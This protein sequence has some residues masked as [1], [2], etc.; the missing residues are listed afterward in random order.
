MINIKNFHIIKKLNIKLQKNPRNKKKNN[1]KI[2]KKVN[3]IPQVRE[4][5]LVSIVL[6]VKKVK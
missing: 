4:V 5:I 1:N 6:L 2:I 3:L